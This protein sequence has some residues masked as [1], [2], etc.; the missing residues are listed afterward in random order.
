MFKLPIDINLIKITHLLSE[1]FKQALF[2]NVNN[3]GQQR[4]AGIIVDQWFQMAL[5]IDIVFCPSLSL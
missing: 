2:T 1:M 3:A 5:K 4:L